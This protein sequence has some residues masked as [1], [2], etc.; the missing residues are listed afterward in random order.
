VDYFDLAE[1]IDKLFEIADDDAY[2]LIKFLDKI[3]IRTRNYLLLS[4]FY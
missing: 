3:E 4:D 2:K 1:L